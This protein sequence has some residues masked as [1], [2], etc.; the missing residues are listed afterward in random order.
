MS[1]Q[2]ALSMGNSDVVVSFTSN[3]GRFK[4]ESGGIYKV[5]MSRSLR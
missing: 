3:Y 5:P 1:L 2:L 4:F